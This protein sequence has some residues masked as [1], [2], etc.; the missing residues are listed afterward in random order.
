MTARPAKP[1]PI[2]MAV[3]PTAKLTINHAARK[4]G[5]TLVEYI[6]KATAQRIAQEQRK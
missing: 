2:V 1:A 3:H 4:A 6:L 5:E